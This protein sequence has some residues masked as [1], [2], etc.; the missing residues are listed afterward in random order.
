MPDV[1][2]THTLDT[3]STPETYVTQLSITRIQY[4]L[5]RA[6][7]LSVMPVFQ[8]LVFCQGM[9]NRLKVSVNIAHYWAGQSIL[10][11]HFG[12]E[13]LLANSDQGKYSN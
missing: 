13:S 8:T 3:T 10:K 4:L 6:H 2:Y 1:T 9:H 12:I 5:H 7:M 11:K